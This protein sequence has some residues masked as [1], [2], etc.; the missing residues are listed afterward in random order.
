MVTILI[1]SFLRGKGF[2]KCIESLQANSAKLHRIIVLQ[3]GDSGPIIPSG[4]DVI[5]SKE[6]TGICKGRNIL[7]QEV[8]TPYM[9]FLDDDCFVEEGWDTYLEEVL[10][11]HQ[12][13]ALTCKLIETRRSR[14]VRER[15]LIRDF[16]LP[17]RNWN[18]FKYSV[19]A[20]TEIE[21]TYVKG[22]SF[23]S[24]KCF[25]ELGG[26]DEEFFI[27]NEDADYSLRLL[28]QKKKILY[29]P[30][31]NIIHEHEFGDL[32]YEKVRWNSDIK[33]KSFERFNEKWTNRW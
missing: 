28:E 15:E 19:P 7:A 22:V 14:I 12:P 32:E 13:D 4:V 20:D 1:L 33:K 29:T 2:I 31:V 16:K 5:I 18:S 8:N 24:V 3:Q 11:N 10:R 27:S 21:C 6:N 23:H 17:L 9:L 30:R 25:R 26:F